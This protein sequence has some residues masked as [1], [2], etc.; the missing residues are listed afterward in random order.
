[1]VVWLATYGSGP[2]TTQSIT[3]I[4]VWRINSVG[5]TQVP[6]IAYPGDVLE[7]DCERHGVRLNGEPRMDLLDPG[8]QFF[9]LTPGQ[10]VTLG[11]EPAG[12]AA[13]ELTYRERWL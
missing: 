4:K 6:Y 9:S 5:P 13:V 1:V 8:S 12:A 3:D 7:I 10:P 2:A 11:V